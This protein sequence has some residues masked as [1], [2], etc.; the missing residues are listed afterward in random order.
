MI[1]LSTVMLEL[2]VAARNVLRQ[3]RRA[4]FA[5]LTIV[6]GVVALMLASGFIEWIFL[7]MRESTIQSQ[8]G[9]VQVVRP[10]YFDGGAADPYANLLPADAANG[11]LQSL[12]SAPGVQVV[13]PRLAF[14]G[15][16]SFGDATLSFSGEGVDPGKEIRLSNGIQ[17]VSG[18]PLSPS[19]PVGLVIGEGL[20]ANLG[21][22]V[23]D[24]VVLLVTTKSGGVNGVECHVRGIFSTYSKAFDDSSLRVPLETVRKLVKVAGATNW[25][26]VLDRTEDTDLFMAQYG[27]QLRGKGFE[28]VPWYQLADFYN[29]T[30]I[31]FS[32]QVGVVKFL[33]GM[34]IILSISNT[35]SMA[36]IERM[37]EIGTVMALGKRRKAVLRMFIIEGA[38]L[39]FLGGAL[40]V[41]VGYILAHIISAIGIPM[42]P[43]PGMAKGY[44]GEIMITWSLVLDAL[45]LAVGT[46]LIASVV[47]AWRASNVIIVDALRHQ[48]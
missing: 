28:A 19:D 48:R 4:L 5:L 25:V 29:K 37:N 6:G 35:L 3:R 30:V 12:A 44:I 39:G 8:L 17:I 46:T 10:R 1:A 45:L 13:T 2:D 14:T 42:P 24:R 47:P 27:E 22:K 32:R 15:L 41:V 34:I 21:V 40:G 43:P 31:L 33:I 7:Q 20:A 18:E 23:G 11:A 36:V 16:V 26:V 38:I 9:H